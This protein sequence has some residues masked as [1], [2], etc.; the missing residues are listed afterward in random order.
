MTGN[1]CPGRGG[2]SARDAAPGDRARAAALL[3]Q[4]LNHHDRGELVEALAAYRE[5]EKAD[6]TFALAYNNAG[7]ALIDLE[8]HEEAV[9][10][11]RRAIAIDPTHSEAYNNLGFV[12]R[13]LRRDLEAADAYE[14]FLELEPDVEEGPRIRQWIEMVRGGDSQAAGAAPGGTVGPGLAPEAEAPAGDRPASATEV[15]GAPA[16]TAAGPAA[17]EVSDG[18]PP[19]PVAGA[20]IHP[21]LPG[22]AREVAVGGTVASPAD[23]PSGA[24][25]RTGHAFLIGSTLPA[26][27]PAAPTPRQIPE[28]PAVQ[29]YAPPPAKTGV[30]AVP[31][32]AAEA[33][34]AKAE[35]RADASEVRGAPAGG[36][37]SVEAIYDAAL[38]KFGDGKFDEAKA[39]FEQALAADPDNAQCHAG[40][41]K[42]L[43]RQENYEAGIAELR[44]AIELD[45]N[46]AGS[47]YVLGYA[48]R[49][50]G[51]EGKAADAYEKFLALMP[52][53]E[54][55]EKIRE[56]IEF[57]RGAAAADAQERET[58]ARVDSAAQAA[59]VETEADRI[60]HEAISK[61]QGG[62]SEGAMK[63]CEQILAMDPK[64]VSAYVLL[65]RIAYRMRE[66]ETAAEYLQ[67]ALAC[68]P[69]CAEALYFLG[70]TFEKRGM[71][72]EAR[73]HYLLYLSVAPDGPRA[74][75]VKELLEGGKPA[76][77]TVEEKAQCSLCLRMFDA[78]ELFP[79]EGSLGCRECL[80]TIEARTGRKILPAAPAPAAAKVAPPEVRVIEKPSARRRLVLV[81]GCVAVLALA[82]AGILEA[83][84]RLR[85]LLRSAGILPPEVAAK[86]GDGNGGK[87]PA[88]GDARPSVPTPFDAS[89]VKVS[90]EAPPEALPWRKVA[91]SVKIEGA[92]GASVSVRLKDAP[93]G[94]KATDIPPGFEWICRP[95]EAA[96]IAALAEGM[97]FP[98]ELTVTGMDKSDPSRILFERTVALKIRV[99]FGFALSDPQ[100]TGVPEGDEVALVAGDVTGDGRPDLVL[101]HGWFRRGEVRLFPIIP[102]ASWPRPKVIPLGGMPS[103]LT[104]ADFNGDG[105]LDM[106]VADWYD[107]E[108]AILLQEAAGGIAPHVRVGAPRSVAGLC[109]LDAT[110]DG[111]PD[112]VVAGTHART[113]SVIPRLATGEKIGFGAAATVEAGRMSP[114]LKMFPW[115][116]R[117]KPSGV[118]LFDGASPDGRLR[119]FR[120]AGG[121]LELCKAAYSTP[122]QTALDAAIVR[123]DKDGPLAVAILF[124][125]PPEVRLLREREGTFSESGG[126]SVRANPAGL[127][128]A[129]AAGDLNEDGLDDM[130][131]VC[132][133]GV[134]IY[135]RDAGEGTFAEAMKVDVPSPLAGPAVIADLNGDGRGD[136][137]LITG[138][139]KIRI[140][141]SRK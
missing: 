9:E 77:K 11:L 136:V 126:G 19:G 37:G 34:G 75:K 74:G 14:K 33:P 139:R 120:R 99:R 31:E 92:E 98:F 22:V 18:A 132:D 42:V 115:P 110:G 69:D 108:V 36:A 76:E 39:L 16:E 48:L 60:Y 21:A 116:D 66:Y 41:G 89:K 25:A 50:I 85:P 100:E 20:A 95:G 54:D 68:D 27:G 79:Y 5:A 3:E 109:V 113:L 28:P 67:R 4:G 128:L 91:G 102:S 70:Q 125:D 83:T 40:L 123:L 55:G 97:E 57:V 44:R 86:T 93:P 10:E 38:D 103:A 35:A 13:R 122:G 118:L 53:A 49:A 29:P 101:A 45:P 134:V 71:H 15:P 114:L 56:W 30:P 84:G 8:R 107:G 12:L 65:G 111:M 80:S 26:P 117:G 90:C 81:F 130:A 46:D 82:A 87:T 6:P 133:Q 137:A 96:P 1:V 127:P 104:L 112:V 43:V 94:A 138:D 62:D 72:E 52:S 2:Q 51:E 105:R 47:Y 61:F 32:A 140:L 141:S 63:D 24:A 106:A 131:V 73:E 121:A 23:V 135:I 59:A 7:M 129:V 119:Y 124:A 78:K 88:P 64:Y 58:D 17:G